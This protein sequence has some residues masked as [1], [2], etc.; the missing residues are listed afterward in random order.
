MYEAGCTHL[1]YGLESF[2]P[3][4]LK[5]L[6]KG[7]TRKNNIESVGVCLNSGIKPIP[8]IIVGSQTKPI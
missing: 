3:K 6:G 5:D 4:I 7:S 1:V 8:N 2:D